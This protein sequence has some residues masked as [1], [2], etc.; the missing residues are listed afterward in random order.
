MKKIERIYWFGR[1]NNNV[2]GILRRKN[3]KIEEE[4]EKMMIK[5]WLNEENG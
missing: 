2:W 4:V 5:E 1:R 3:S